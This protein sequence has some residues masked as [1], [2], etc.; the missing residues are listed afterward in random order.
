MRRGALI[1]IAAVLLGLAV[2]ATAEADARTDFLV[3]M[4]GSSSQF[5]VRVQ[6][7]LALGAQQADPSC[8]RRFLRARADN[9]CTS[10][11]S[12]RPKAQAATIQ[13]R[14]VPRQSRR[15]RQR[16]PEKSPS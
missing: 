14:T 15:E 3:R 6:A 7:A 5:R 16:A 10:S 9:A 8:S 13:R 11:A 12:P 4:L 2:A 1:Q